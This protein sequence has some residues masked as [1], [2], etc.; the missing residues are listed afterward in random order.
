MTRC[1]NC[2]YDLK[3]TCPKCFGKI[4]IKLPTPPAPIRPGENPAVYNLRIGIQRLTSRR[5]FVV[6]CED[7]GWTDK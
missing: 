3:S 5:K 4:V 6:Q 7:C 2:N 1:P